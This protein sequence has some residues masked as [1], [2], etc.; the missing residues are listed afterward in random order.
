MYMK[1]TVGAGEL[2]QNLSRYLRHVEKGER[3][4]ATDRNQPVALLG[5]CPA[6]PSLTA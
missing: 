4:L 6:A 5:P 2:R 1:S 3:L